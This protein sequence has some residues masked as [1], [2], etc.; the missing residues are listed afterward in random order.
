[1]RLPGAVVNLSLELCIAS[2]ALG[3]IADVFKSRSF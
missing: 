1:V 2:Y 3:D